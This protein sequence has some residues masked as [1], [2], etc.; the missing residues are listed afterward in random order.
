M[1]PAASFASTSS[2]GAPFAPPFSLPIEMPS[3][4]VGESSVSSVSLRAD[5]RRRRYSSARFAEP[6]SSP[7]SELPASPRDEKKGLSAFFSSILGSSKKN[8]SESSS[9]PLNGK[10]ATSPRRSTIGAQDVAMRQTIDGLGLSRRQTIDEPTRVSQVVPQKTMNQP[11]AAK[12]SAAIPLNLEA[13]SKS[14]RQTIAGLPKEGQ[15][16]AKPKKATLK[17]KPEDSEKMLR[18]WEGLEVSYGGFIQ[19]VNKAQ[20]K[21]KDTH[22]E[23]VVR[24]EADLK[25]EKEALA[26]LNKKLDQSL[27]PDLHFQE[28]ARAHLQSGTLPSRQEAYSEEIRLEMARQVLLFGV[29]QIHGTSNDV[30]ILYTAPEGFPDRRPLFIFKS[31]HA[32]ADRSSNSGV[33]LVVDQRIWSH[34]RVGFPI[35]E[36]CLRE[37]ALSALGE[38]PIRVMGKLQLLPGG[39]SQQGVLIDYVPHLM[40]VEKLFGYLDQTRACKTANGGSLQTSLTSA[41]Q[42]LDGLSGSLDAARLLQGFTDA[43]KILEEVTGIQKVLEGLTEDQK[44]LVEACGEWSGRHRYELPL[45]SLVSAASIETMIIQTFAFPDFDR[46]SGNYLISKSIEENK[47]DITAID[48]DQAFSDTLWMKQKPQILH[49]VNTPVWVGHS[50]FDAPLKNLQT[51]TDRIKSF[52]ANKLLKD[53]QAKGIVFQEQSQKIKKPGDGE[54]WTIGGDLYTILNAF[55]TVAKIALINDNTPNQ[56]ARLL[57]VNGEL[58]KLVKLAK[59][60]EVFG[61]TSS[62]ESR[63]YQRMRGSAIY[64]ECF[65]DDCYRDEDKSFWQLFEALTLQKLSPVQVKK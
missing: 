33:G 1:E 65:P 22:L 57:F 7:R 8:L 37:Y 45:W 60:A 31:F 24:L 46:N 29:T 61:D 56:A 4:R 48:A 49:T 32:L 15:G 53:L 54:E 28:T 35:G 55:H 47:F 42:I 26:A 30:Y 25:K 13:P 14:V 20:L 59:G 44:Q 64:Q 9:P 51:V 63:D 40:T 50:M 43:K 18:L 34:D 58:S 39:I 41:L 21:E 6:L 11:D 5:E 52:N 62:Y 38:N 12:N 36:A 2:H 17:S 19:N 27:K 16:K 10:I 3:D 23:K